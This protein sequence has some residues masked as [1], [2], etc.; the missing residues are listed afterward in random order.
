MTARVN[1]GPCCAD[2]C[3][4]TAFAKGLCG[5][6]YDR[7]RRTGALDLAPRTSFE[8]RLWQRVE[9]R[10]DGCWVWV[11]ALNGSGYGVVGRDSKVYRVHRIVYELLVRSIPDGLDLDHLCRNRACCNPAHLE[12]VTNRENWLRGQHPTA[13]TVRTDR[14]QR[15]HSMADAQTRPNGSRYCK[16][17]AKAAQLRRRGAA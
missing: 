14:C 16:P 3:P 4:R 11:A 8:D 6:H 7:Q 15:G 17:C 5:M 9:K 12:P 1:G 13:V 10:P 2:G